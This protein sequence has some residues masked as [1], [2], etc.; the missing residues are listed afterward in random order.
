[1]LVCPI[2]L[3]SMKGYTTNKGDVFVCPRCGSRAALLRSL[4]KE[5]SPRR[6]REFAQSLWTQV[7][8]GKTRPGRPCPHCREKT[9]STPTPGQDAV[10]LDVCTRCG[11][12]FF[13]PGEYRL[14]YESQAA[15]APPPPQA[16]AQRRAA[17]AEAAASERGVGGGAE[18]YPEVNAP[19]PDEDAISIRPPDSAWQ[20]LPALL[21]L[22][23]ELGRDQVV[24]RPYVTY[25]LTLVMSLMFLWLWLTGALDQAVL[26]WGFI[27]NLWDRH[28]G[29]TLLTSFLLHAGW[30]HIISNMYFLMVFGNNVEDRLGAAGYILLLALAHLTGLAVDAAFGGHGHQ[31]LVGASGA[32]SGVIG[33]YAIAFP[34]AQIG[35]MPSIFFLFIGMVRMPAI[36]ALFFFIG[37]QILGAF[38]E[39]AG[40]SGVASLAHLGGLGVGVAFG[41]AARV[42]SGRMKEQPE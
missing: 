3:S 2:C 7:C 41:A 16:G 18:Y 5:S 8:A 14:L 28:G 9:L 4:R 19:A 37:I 22:P 25:G 32:I 10:W 21:G 6:V 1:M 29:A 35:V 36:V 11:I 20:Y 30:F 39:R 27:P 40:I 33:Y 26:D 24:R 42:F 34:R 31:A 17:E 15:A 23:V 38:L 12:V 13:D